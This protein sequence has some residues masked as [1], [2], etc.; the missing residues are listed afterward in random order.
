MTVFYHAFLEG[1]SACIP[2]RRIHIHDMGFDIKTVDRISRVT[3]IREVC[4]A[5][6][7]VTIADYCTEAAERLLSEMEFDRGRIDGIVFVTPQP[8]YIVPATAGVLQ[9]R[10]GIPKKCVAIDM[11]HGCTGFLYGLFQGFLMVESG[12]CKHVLVC[13]GDAPTRLLHPKDKSVRLIHGDGGAA[14]LVSA[15]GGNTPSAFSFLHDGNGIE[16]LYIPA[17]GART[18]RA[19][20]ITDVERE[21][22]EGNIRTLETIH[23]NGMEVMRFALTEAP[24]L[25]EEVRR[26]LEWQQEDVTTFAFHQ[27]NAFMVKSL[28]KQMMLPM[29]KVLLDVEDVGNI[30]AASLGLLLCRSAQKGIL[31]AKQ[32]IMCAFGTGLSCVAAGMDLSA[33]YFSP[34]HEISFAERKPFP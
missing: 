24:H 11:N 2:R 18:P 32:T 9:R 4:V 25:I 34:V 20:G 17:G 10:L 31:C 15:S 12:F 6:K 33:T 28:A 30:G 22:E 13:C 3:G 19:P 1:V 8:D 27:A 5:E 16:H 26:G 7:G 23:M 29:E 21:E 14:M